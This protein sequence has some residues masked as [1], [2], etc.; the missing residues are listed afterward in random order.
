MT[1]DI[2]VS[3]AAVLIVAAFWYGRWYERQWGRR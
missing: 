2:I 3:I 1:T